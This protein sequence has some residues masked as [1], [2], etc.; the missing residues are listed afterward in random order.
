MHRI[1]TDDEKL[2][3]FKNTKHKKSWVDPGQQ[4]TSQPVRNI[5]G[6]KALLCILW[7][8]KRAVYY[9]LLKSGETVTGNRYRQKLIKLNQA[10]KIK[11][12]EWRDRTRKTFCSGEGQNF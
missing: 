8:Q 7:D 9:K 4:S 6:K 2:I 11:Q 5:H 10:L 12:P 3:Y 1:V